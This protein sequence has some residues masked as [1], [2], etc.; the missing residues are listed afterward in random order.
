MRLLIT[1]RKEA[2]N[3]KGDEVFE[4]LVAVAG[5]LIVLAYSFI[6]VNKTDPLPFFGFIE[7]VRVGFTLS[8]FINHG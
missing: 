5:F 2:P 4:I 6:Y 1:G 7:I 3:S 8:G